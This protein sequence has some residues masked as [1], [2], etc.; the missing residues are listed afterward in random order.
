MSLG[1]GHA[2][3]YSSGSLDDDMSD[4]GD[5][6]MDATNDTRMR[7]M[8]AMYY[9]MNSP[10]IA[11]GDEGAADAAPTEATSSAGDGAGTGAGASAGAGAGA[12]AGA[13]AA[14]AGAQA[15]PASPGSR[16]AGVKI[17]DET[18]DAM[19]HVRQLLLGG[20]LQK[21]LET[22]DKMVHDVKTLDSDLQM[23]V[24]ENY[25]KF[26]SATDTIRNMK[27]NVAGMDGKMDA[28]LGDMGRISETASAIQTAVEPGL[29]RVR[30][31]VKIRRL[32]ERLSFLLSLPQSLKD[33]I[34]NG[35]EAH[36]IAI[37]RSTSTILK[38]HEHLSSFGAIRAE[39]VDIMQQ[40]KQSLGGRLRAGLGL[41]QT[42]VTC[43]LL[44]CIG[45]TDHEAPPGGA[46]A[47]TADYESYAE[48][49]G[50]DLP[51]ASALPPGLGIW[52]QLLIALE[53]H[54]DARL[55]SLRAAASSLEAS[56]AALLAARPLLSAF[57]RDLAAAARACVRSFKA[58]L[59]FASDDSED[60]VFAKVPPE[61][62]RAQL[63]LARRCL[64]SAC[65]RLMAAFVKPLHAFLAAALEADGA[66]IDGSVAAEDLPAALLQRSS[67]GAANPFADMD[68]EEG[69]PAPREAPRGPEG[70]AAAAFDGVGV[71]RSF[72]EDLQL[73]PGALEELADEAQAAK[74]LRAALEARLRSA[75]EALGLECREALRDLA[76]SAAEAE[77]EELR[78]V[79]AAKS[80]FAE[81]RLLGGCAALLRRLR[82]TLEVAA[83]A[84]W[85]PRGAL[86][87][88]VAAHVWSLAAN[89]LRDAQRLGGAAHAAPMAALPDG[90]GVGE[91]S[92]RGAAEGLCGAAGERGA[93]E[94]ERAT[95]E[96]CAA[97][98]LSSCMAAIGRSC[99]ERL[100]GALEGAGVGV[101]AEAPARLR[102]AFEEAS[103]RL[104]Q[105]FCEESAARILEE[106][107]LRRSIGAR[108]LMG[109]ERLKGVR[110]AVRSAAGDLLR[111]AERAGRVL[112]EWPPAHGAPS[113]LQT[114]RLDGRA[115][116]A[117]D[118]YLMGYRGPE[119]A[120][121]AFARDVDLELAN[122]ERTLV[123]GQ[124]RVPPMSA[125]RDGL[126][127]CALAEGT[128]Q[129][130]LRGVLE[131]VRDT[132]AFSLPGFQQLHLDAAF[133]RALAPL[134]TALP[135]AEATRSLAPIIDDIVQAAADNFLQDGDHTAPPP[136][137]AAFLVSKCSEA[138][139]RMIEEAE[140]AEEA[141][142]E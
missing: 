113:S 130:F 114:L 43:H 21:L 55:S 126:T 120:G 99:E 39:S 90:A 131:V 84:E 96:L 106:S 112:Q 60:E 76:L 25:S 135:E 37:Y 29:D 49:L 88:A 117:R 98:A 97:V 137:E 20:G 19:A 35:Q 79:C 73:L 67:S 40:L 8:L 86:D 121:G 85:M 134:M 54:F 27:A 46:A 24:Y 38:K 140:A 7:D 129:L 34:A 16:S 107:G 119:S 64:C 1:P 142:A 82:P 108:S 33:A 14:P 75:F 133:L 66:P 44:C 127:L 87:G 105:V 118:G 139:R 102:E 10:A 51:F 12:G 56:P 18:F 61:E 128:A 57:L 45:G 109:P 81:E 124:R 68:D 22:D 91:E 125:A 11:E 53:G 71:L 52:G 77:P 92:L 78:P 74:V 116:A 26:I 132:A 122:I 72:L 123:Q 50:V 6:S 100:A 4:S 5:G 58:A 17:D 31:L 3:T 42:L 9:G 80:A 70:G 28:L 23:L 138:R 110:L 59:R 141:A 13:A 30:E 63:E 115:L 15:A 48:L 69:A 136:L 2:R 95:E 103:E 32:L 89:A 94:A 83:G 36:A 111:L 104:A 93:A 47:P 62:A 41:K 65:R 101:G